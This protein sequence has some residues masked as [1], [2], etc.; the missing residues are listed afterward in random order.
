MRGVASPEVHPGE[1]D[2]QEG[3]SGHGLQE[4]PEGGLRSQQL[5]DCPGPRNLLRR[6]QV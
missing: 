5:R 6:S 4:D 3:S 1:E 2:G